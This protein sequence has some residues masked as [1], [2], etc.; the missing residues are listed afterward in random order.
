MIAAHRLIS[1][2]PTIAAYA[3]KY[4]QGQPFMYPRNNMATPRTSCT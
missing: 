4:A 1:K 2:M 3:Y